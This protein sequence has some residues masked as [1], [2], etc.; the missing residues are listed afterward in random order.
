MTK[1]ALKNYEHFSCRL[2]KRAMEQLN[3]ISTDVGL[4][5][6]KIIEKAI[7]RYYEEYKKTGKV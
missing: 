4:T 5:K 6:T 7:G 1:K 2:D 3:E